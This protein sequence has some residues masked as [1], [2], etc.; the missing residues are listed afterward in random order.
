[1]GCLGEAAA[2]S[3][4]MDL[5]AGEFSSWSFE[6]KRGE[7]LG[8]M[9]ESKGHEIRAYHTSCFWP[10]TLAAGFSFSVG[11]MVVLKAL[12]HG[13]T[14]LTLLLLLLLLVNLDAVAGP[15]RENMDM[16]AGEGC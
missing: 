3:F 11:A 8:E 16:G 6:T 4:I 13:R 2:A 14:S 5:C 1:M 9:E 15:S 12:V 10:E 7:E